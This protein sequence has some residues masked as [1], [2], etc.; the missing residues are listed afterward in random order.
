MNLI[1]KTFSHQIFPTVENVRASLE[2]Y[3]GKF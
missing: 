3:V 1:E 2:G